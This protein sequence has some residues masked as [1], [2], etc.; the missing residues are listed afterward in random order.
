MA[1]DTEILDENA[2]VLILISRLY[3]ISIG[4]LR[5]LNPD[6][7]EALLEQHTAGRIL[8]PDISLNLE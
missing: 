1:S 8:L 7:A 5:E 4:I 6:A 2:A 3:D